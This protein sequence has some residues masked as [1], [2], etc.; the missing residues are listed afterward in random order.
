MFVSATYRAYL[1]SEAGAAR[2]ST[3]HP[4]LPPT[5]A[6]ATTFTTAGLSSLTRDGRCTDQIRG[7]V[8]LLAE[9]QR[10][11]FEHPQGPEVN[12]VLDEWALRAIAQ[13]ASRIDQLDYLVRLS[14]HPR[15]HCVIM[16]T[17][18]ADPRFMCGPC[19]ILE[20][21]AP[22]DRSLVTSGWWGVDDADLVGDEATVAAWV[23]R[24]AQLREASLTE[25][26]S[27]AHLVE[28]RDRLRQVTGR[29][30]AGGAVSA[31]ALGGL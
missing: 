28:L 24:F 9:R 1:E 27:A 8:S 29:A 13:H 26:R 21:D 5:I 17:T 4:G 11:L 7:I 30:A 25:A 18:M 31:G 19:N 10:R 22:E 14:R 16:P 6:Q 23:R 15:V 3:F 20:F 12:I 2:I